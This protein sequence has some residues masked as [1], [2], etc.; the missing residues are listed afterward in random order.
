MLLLRTVNASIS[1]SFLSF[2]LL[3]FFFGLYFEP[4]GDGQ[5]QHGLVERLGEGMV[6]KVVVQEGEAQQA[7]NKLEVQQVI[8]HAGRVPV[9]L[10]NEKKKNTD[11]RGNTYICINSLDHEKY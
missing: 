7:A 6:D 9:D 8:I 10:R 3:L 4:E 11:I 2:I 5:A 1:I